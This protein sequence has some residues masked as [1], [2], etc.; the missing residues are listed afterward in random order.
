ME[1]HRTRKQRSY[2]LTEPRSW[3]CRRRGESWGSTEGDRTGG[4][5]QRCESDRQKGWLRD[6]KR[7][8]YGV[9]SGMRKGGEEKA[10]PKNGARSRGE[11]AVGADGAAG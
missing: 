9:S 4:W 3:E 6:G 2:Y 11:K 10:R 1:T 7:F 5:Q 8:F